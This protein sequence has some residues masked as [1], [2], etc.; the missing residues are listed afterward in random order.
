MG[1]NVSS[2]S[3]AREITNRDTD[4]F[5]DRQRRIVRKTWRPL[6]N[7]MTGNGTK[8]FLRIFEM[9]P[10]V[11]QLFPCRD[12]EGEE[13]L[14]DMNFKGHASRFM[15]SVGAAVDNLDSLETSLAPLLLKLGRSHTNF[16][17]FKP[18]YFDIF[19]R[20]MLDVWEQELKDRFTSEVKESWL[21]V[22]E[23]MMGKMK[24]GYMQAYTEEMN[25]KNLQ[26]SNGTVVDE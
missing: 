26:K 13:L 7:D 24:E 25:A 1:C 11:K 16:S 22:F 19:T 20:A 4:I 18:D 2:A 21:T 3:Q 23:F 9:E 6:A 15:Q 17:G 12:K 10:K 5:T 14:K 8:V